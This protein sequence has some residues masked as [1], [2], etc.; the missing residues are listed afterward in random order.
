MSV[1]CC[2][3]N[4]SSV[5][6]IWISFVITSERPKSCKLDLGICVNTWPAIALSSLGLYR[7]SVIFLVS[8]LRFR[9]G[10]GLRIIN[11]STRGP[12]SPGYLPNIGNA[13]IPAPASYIRTIQQLEERAS[14]Q[15]KAH[16]SAIF[17]AISSAVRN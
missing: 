9:L 1:R 5:I 13:L 2:M 12:Y 4:L 10:L 11:N 14:R 15:Q 7:A 3:R 8:G 6:S 17:T 16:C